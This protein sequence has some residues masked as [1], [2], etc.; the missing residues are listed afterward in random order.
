MTTINTLKIA[1]QKLQLLDSLTEDLDYKMKTV[2][3]EIQSSKKY[4]AEG[5]ATDHPDLRLD[6][7]EYREKVKE[8]WCWGQ[9]QDQLARAAAIE[10]LKK[11][12]E[13]LAGIK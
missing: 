4:I 2:H 13:K 11:D 5:M 7:E 6:S 9:L 8:Q 1:V 12:F 3:D 10:Q